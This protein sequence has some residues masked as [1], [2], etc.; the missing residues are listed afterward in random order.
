M[1]ISWSLPL[2]PALSSSPVQVP[3]LPG[4]HNVLDFFLPLQ[5]TVGVAPDAVPWVQ[6][7]HA[8]S[9]QGIGIIVIGY[10]SPNDVFY[11]NGDNA[12]QCF[13]PWVPQWS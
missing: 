13:L 10:T 6:Y 4:F 9:L 2:I 7:F 1:L 8:K 5:A 12:C 3:S 11:F